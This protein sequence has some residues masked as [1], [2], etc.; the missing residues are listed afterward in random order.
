MAAGRPSHGVRLGLGAADVLEAPASPP[1]VLHFQFL[2]LEEVA[3]TPEAPWPAI[4]GA[5]MLG[6][7]VPFP[8]LAAASR[9]SAPA[10]LTLRF[11]NQQDP[12][13][14]VPLPR[15]AFPRGSPR[16]SPPT[17]RESQASAVGETYWGEGG[18]PVLGVSA[19]GGR[20]SPPPC[21]GKVSR[22]L[23]SSRLAGSAQPLSARLSTVG[24][25]PPLLL[26]KRHGRRPPLHG[27]L[28]ERAGPG[29]GGEGAPGGG[30][31]LPPSR[32]VQPPLARLRE[33]ERRGRAGRRGRRALPLPPPPPPRPAPTAAAAAS[34][35]SSAGA[36]ARAR[37]SRLPETDAPA[38]AAAA[39]A[40]AAGGRRGASTAATAGAAAA[41]GAAAGAAAAG[42]PETWLDSLWAAGLLRRHDGYGDEAAAEG[43][44]P[45]SGSAGGL[46]CRLDQTIQGHVGPGDQLSTQL[47]RNKQLQDTLMQKEE[48]LARLQEENNHLRQ[49]LN[50]ALI[51]QL[52]EKTKKLLL[53][54]NQKWRAFK[55][56]KRRLKPESPPPPHEVSHPQKARRNLLAD[57]STC[58]EPPHP[59]VVDSWVLRTL[60]LKDVNTID[61]KSPA[62]ANYSALTVGL[63][64]GSFLGDPLGVAADFGTSHRQPAL[65]RCA[66][67]H[68]LG[69]TASAPEVPLPY[70]PEGPA[71]PRPPAPRPRSPSLLPGGVASR[72]LLPTRKDV[73]F[74]ASLSPHCNVKTHTFRQGQ[75][76]VR[77]DPD[78][79]WKLTWV[80]K[81]PE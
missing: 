67:S 34:P 31:W 11:A 36:A 48:E 77:R 41:E 27:P 76:F 5:K 26:L 51:Q 61:E 35:L 6:P 3:V 20:S 16:R 57:F 22:T 75:A 37:S 47:Y 71:S 23:A 56:G 24:A 19:G 70:L 50:S 81:Q 1:V 13:E 15:R 4:L 80:P 59:S 8:G 9:P 63:A 79:G 74:T 73:A 21:R 18:I 78:G 7:S 44:A 72:D 53:Q 46:L 45:A 12:A 43:T 52:E 55:S 69:T 28:R 64:P 30:A 2:Q 25:G 58:E 29:R 68:P 66:A 39:A 65:Y 62:S 14:R 54:N 40:A 60:G 10:E 42:P 33:A 17:R 32:P 38:A 49:F